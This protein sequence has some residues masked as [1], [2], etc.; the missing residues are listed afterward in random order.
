MTGSIKRTTANFNLRIPIFDAPGWGREIERDLDILDATLYAA[1]GFTNIIGAW[2]NATD[3]HVGEYLVDQDNNSL[4]RC[5]VDH[6]SAAS[7][8]FQDDRTA[9]PTYWEIVNRIVNFRGEWDGDADYLVNDFLVDG[10]RYGVVTQNYSAG[11]S[12]DAD[13]LA[14]N[15]LTLVD[16]TVP[17]DDANQAVSDAQGHANAA[18]NSAQSAESYAVSAALIASFVQQAQVDVE[19]AQQAAEDARD[20][21]QAAQSAAENAQSAAE[22]AQSAAEGAQSAAEDAQSTAESAASDAQGYAVSASNSADAAANAKT[23]A[24]TAQGL[25]EAAKIDAETAQ[26][27]AEDA[28]DLAEGYKDSAAQS[29]STA[30]D[31]KDDAEYAR[32][33]AVLAKGDAES[34]RDDAIQAKDDAEDAR[35]SAVLAKGDAETARDEAVQAKEDAEAARDQANNIVGNLSG[36]LA[37]QFLV[38]NSNSDYDYG[39]ANISGGGDMLASVYDPNGVA[40]D[41]FDMDNMVEGSTNLILTAAERADIAANTSDR[42]SHSNKSILD[43]TEQSFTTALKSKLDDAV[44]SA[45]VSTIVVLTQ[46]DY[47]EL[48]PPNPNVLYIIK[49]DEE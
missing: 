1:T 18:S 36:G 48:D 35:D 15:I 45:D 26:G 20:D 2:S 30:S 27:L 23:A 9:H 47:D 5:R 37:G 12:Y 49:E 43:A 28:R 14:G 6:T 29:S 10:Y 31:A 41:A 11:A 38:K 32:D 25:A 24:E 13:V 7:G 39:W 19:A 22:N 4:W 21:A 46:E 44:T 33:A 17:M 34:A 3:Y 8:S 42:H 40:A 16:L